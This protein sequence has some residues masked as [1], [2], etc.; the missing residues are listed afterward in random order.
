VRRL[1]EALQDDGYL[2]I[3]HNCGNRGHVTR[4][5][6]STGAR[7]L[8]FGNQADMLQALRDVPPDRLVMGNLDP[9]GLLKMGT[10]A[11]VDAATAALLDATVGYPNFVLSTGCDTPPGVPEENIA[12]LFAALARANR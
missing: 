4:S 7:G 2:F 6:V 3:L 10:P 8:H 9:A 1:V 12:A 5:M 11:A